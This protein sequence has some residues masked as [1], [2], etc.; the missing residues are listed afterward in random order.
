MTNP[1]ALYLGS[2]FLAALLWIAVTV[3]AS[4]I[5]AVRAARTVKRRLYELEMHSI[6]CGILR[7][8]NMELLSI[9][10]QL[11]YRGLL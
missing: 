8:G 4:R 6:F 5:Q 9:F 11:R 2:S 10:L 7:S 1:I 3:V